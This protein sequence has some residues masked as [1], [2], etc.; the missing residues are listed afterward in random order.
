MLD[1]SAL[2]NLLNSCRVD[3]KAGIRVAMMNDERR[4]T[5]EHK[6]AN[7]VEWKNNNRVRVDG[8]RSGR[9]RERAPTPTI[10]SLTLQQA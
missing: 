4:S 6:D 9:Q 2:F 5:T 10:R 3:D 7:E 1:I 8:G